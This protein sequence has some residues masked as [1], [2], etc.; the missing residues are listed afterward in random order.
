MNLKNL[1][2]FP[3]KWCMAVCFGSSPTKVH[4]SIQSYGFSS[5]HVWMWELDCKESWAPKNWSFKLWCWRRL[6]RVPWT[7]RRS[8][9]FILKEISPEYSLEGLSWQTWTKFTVKYLCTIEVS[10]NRLIDWS[11][12]HWSQP[13][14]PSFFPEVQKL[15]TFILLTECWVF[16]VECWQ[17]LSCMVIKLYSGNHHLTYERE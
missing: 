10:R 14:C 2:T 8:N 16:N 9:Q 17:F 4:L 1:E 7:S 3:G 5:G 6:L 15:Q 11:V 12:G 13:Q